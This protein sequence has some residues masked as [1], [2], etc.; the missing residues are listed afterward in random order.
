MDRSL[1]G[2][3]DRYIDQVFGLDDPVLVEALRDAAAAGL[4]SIAVSAAQGKFLQIMARAI[5]ARRILEI[6]TLAGYSTIWLGRA[7]GPGGRLISL[8]IDA[9]RAGV[10]RAN[11]ARAGLSESVEVRVG[12][13]IESLRQMIA[14]GAGPFDMVFMD[15]DEPSYVDYLEAALRLSHRGTLIVADNV[16][17]E[18]AVIDAVSAEARVQ[19]ARRFNRALA[20]DERLT[21]TVIP[22]VGENSSDG[23]AIALVVDPAAD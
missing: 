17:R 1:F 6:G 13:A 7:L 3:V 2:A 16:V 12:P 11:I 21:A 18:G 10:A 22:L 5:G 20:A 4:P 14:T 8:E 19:G 15:A 23:L 9:V